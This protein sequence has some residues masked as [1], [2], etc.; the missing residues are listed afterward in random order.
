MNVINFLRGKM[1]PPEKILTT[2][3]HGSVNVGLYYLTMI[4]DMMPTIW[5]FA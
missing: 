1:H 5:R 3:M 4:N 2:P